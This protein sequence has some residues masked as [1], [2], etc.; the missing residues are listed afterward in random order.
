MSNSKRAASPSCEQQPT[1]K[2]RLLM[3]PKSEAERQIL[4]NLNAHLVVQKEQV[5]ELHE[6]LVP[7]SIQRDDNALRFSSV[8][9]IADDANYCYKLTTIWPEVPLFVESLE[10]LDDMLSDLSD[11]ARLRLLAALEARIVDK[12]T[13]IAELYEVVN[14]LVS[15]MERGFGQDWVSF[16][17]KELQRSRCVPQCKIATLSKLSQIFQ[18]KLRIMNCDFDGVMSHFRL[19]TAMI[20]Y[21]A[22]SFPDKTYSESK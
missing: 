22:R 6:K 10:S 18:G 4:S 17:G 16:S 11:A 1:S 19:L 2:L 20:E 8:C 12:A 13:K 15:A 3:T 21:I 5:A 7:A 9:L 14:T